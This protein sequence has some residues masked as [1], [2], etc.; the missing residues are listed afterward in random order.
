MKKLLNTIILTLVGTFVFSQ[1]ISVTEF[2]RWDNDLTTRT[3]GVRDMNGD[4][5][6]LII[7]NT[8]VQGFEFSVANIEKTEQKTGEIWLFVSPGTRFITL[9]HRDLGSLRNYNFPQSIESGK[10]YEMVLRTA[11]ITQIVEENITDQYL[12]IRSNTP[13]A[14]IFI[15]DEYVGKN[16]AQK[17]L[18][19][20]EEHSYR[21]EAPL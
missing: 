1:S 20:F 8:P 2:R 21:V 16:N 3:E 6:A 12:I 11:K 9:K 13:E 4:L 10:T 5:C 15:N 17:Y 14:K 19:L 7:V 18:P